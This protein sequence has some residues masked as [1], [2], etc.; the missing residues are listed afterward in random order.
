[1]FEDGER[2]RTA[3]TLANA[4][5]VKDEIA[6]N[7]KAATELVDSLRA[8]M[9]QQMQGQG[10]AHLQVAGLDIHIRNEQVP[11]LHDKEALRAFLQDT[12]RMPDFT[13]YDETRAKRV[14]AKSGWPGAS[15]G[16]RQTLV[17]RQVVSDE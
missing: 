13:K 4:M 3:A 17:V 12:G 5:R 16:D 7:Y 8:D 9:L 15:L 10:I 6:D 14:A 1:M 11:V 2:E